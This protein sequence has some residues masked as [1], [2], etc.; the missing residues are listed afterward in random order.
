MTVYYLL[1][2]LFFRLSSHSLLSEYEVIHYWGA[3]VA[4][5]KVAA[6]QLS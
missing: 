3:A 4:F 1:L 5:V 2:T 6:N